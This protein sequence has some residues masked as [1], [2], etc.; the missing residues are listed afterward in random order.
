MSE[1]SKSS[2]TISKKSLLIFLSGLTIV[3]LLAYI[4]GVWLGQ[5]NNYQKQLAYSDL[6][7]RE[8][9]QKVKEL[10]QTQESSQSSE[11]LEIKELGLKLELNS[12]NDDLYYVVE[13]IPSESTPQLIHIST[14]K[15]QQI[16]DQC[17]AENGG[18][19]TISASDRTSYDQQIEYGSSNVRKIGE[20]YIRIE[21]ALDSCN[22][23]NN[24]E[25][26]K[27]V[28]F[29]YSTDILPL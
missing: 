10:S 18:L 17:S 7:I 28:D 6:Q 5:S 26:I 22:E 13:K 8:L 9:E 16:N 29:L 27:I 23:D 12:E 21:N 14:R 24:S 2:I 25:I 4:G 20:K 19:M 15:A 11:F 1:K 3:L